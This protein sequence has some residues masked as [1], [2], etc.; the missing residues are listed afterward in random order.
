MWAPKWC[1]RIFVCWD[2][3]FCLRL[4]WILSV[5][6]LLHNTAPQFLRFYLNWIW[7]MTMWCTF[8]M[9]NRI[10]FGGVSTWCP[11]RKI[12]VPNTSPHLR[13]IIYNE[14]TIFL[15]N[16]NHSIILHR[17]LR[18][19]WFSLVLFLVNVSIFRQHFTTTTINE[20]LRIHKS[21]QN[22]H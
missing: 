11:Q 9:A 14:S 17:Y 10:L 1:P 2:N 13:R 8:M 22:L 7:G 20:K 6:C 12:V 3:Y 15:Q 19:G 21:Y 18:A 5:Q 4:R 16:R